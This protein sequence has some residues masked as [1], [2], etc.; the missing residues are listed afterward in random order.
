M[1]EGLVTVVTGGGS[2]IGKALCEQLAQR[3]AKVAVA[4]LFAQAAQATA[5]AI[6]NDARAYACDVSDRAQV[7]SLAANVLRDFGTLNLAF[8]NA[9]VAIGGK[10][11]D[12]D[13]REFQWLFDVNVGGVF[14]SIQAFV[15]LL[16]AA[17]EKGQT[18]RFI[19]TGSE[20]S[21]GL[22]LTAPSSAYTATKHAVLGLTDALRRDLADTGVGVSIF[23]PG[24][25]ATRV[26][27]ARRSRQDRYG[28]A[29]A[30]PADYAAHAEKAMAQFGMPP[31]RTAQLTIE[32]VERGD[33]LIITDPRIRQITTPREQAIN[34]ALDACETRLAQLEKQ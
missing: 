10:I 3:G 24:V 15:P 13:P 6:G 22:P 30:M 1:F 4:D 14:N 32:G 11:M 28:G 33:F 34:A 20:N 21:V 12:T 26:W 2:G 25:V 23:C 8:A 17:A 7:D 9:G 27:D 31:D 18:S 29:S 5:D 16:I 19:C